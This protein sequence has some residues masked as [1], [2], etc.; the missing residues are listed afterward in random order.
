M[1]C[2][3]VCNSLEDF[4]NNWLLVTCLPKVQESSHSL[5]TICLLEN[6]V[7]AEFQHQILAPHTSQDHPWS[8]SVRLIH[9]SE[10]YPS[11]KIGPKDMVWSTSLLDPYVDQIRLTKI[12]NP[13][14]FSIAVAT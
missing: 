14:T 6:Q 2:R 11:N 9:Y 7:F 5:L 8:E 12:T 13:I 3:L 1:G 10:T 4:D